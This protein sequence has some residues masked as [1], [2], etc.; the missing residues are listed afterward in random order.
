MD[1]VNEKDSKAGGLQ[2]DWF[3]LVRI[4]RNCETASYQTEQ[5]DYEAFSAGNPH[6]IGSEL[7]GETEKS[8][9]NEAVGYRKQFSSRKREG[10]RWCWC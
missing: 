8:R 1:S 2:S 6:N 5:T 10:F 9:Q 4:G 7:A 3:L